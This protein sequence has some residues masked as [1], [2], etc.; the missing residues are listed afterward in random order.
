MFQEVLLHPHG[1]QHS[2]PFF[3]IGPNGPVISV[4]GVLPGVLLGYAQCWC[5][6][7]GA[8]KMLVIKLRQELA[9]RSKGEI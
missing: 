1:A 4:N 2:F 8:I 9:S 5:S 3:L 6:F 7:H